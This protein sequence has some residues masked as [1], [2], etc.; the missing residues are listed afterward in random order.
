MVRLFSLVRVRKKAWA[1]RIRSAMVAGAVLAMCCL[2]T[3]Q[4]RS[5]GLSWG[6]YLAPSISRSLGWS[7]SHFFVILLWWV[8]PMPL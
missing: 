5:T 2:S 3:A 6:L 8:L 7:A 4:I 1:C